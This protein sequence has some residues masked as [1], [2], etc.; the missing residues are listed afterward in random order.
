[1]LQLNMQK[2]NRCHV[3]QPLANFHKDNSRRIGYC[4]ECKV[5]KANRR[6]VLGEMLANSKS[7]AKRKNWGHD[8]TR[9][10]FVHLKAKQDNKCHYCGVSLNWEAA[11]QFK[12]RLCPPDRVSLDRIDSTKGYTI[13]N[14]QLVCDFC[15]RFKFSYPELELLDYC[16]RVI[17]HAS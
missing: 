3:E 16:R 17:A 5:C 8:L 11:P 2:C 6:S 13:D 14:V 10:T 1:M 9:A 12:Q 15:N 7:R 4:A